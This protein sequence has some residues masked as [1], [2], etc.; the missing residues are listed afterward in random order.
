MVVSLFSF[1]KL[2]TRWNEKLVTHMVPSV[3]FLIFYW[4][5]K[6]KDSGAPVCSS[7]GEEEAEPLRGETLPQIPLPMSWGHIP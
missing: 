2:L 7:F 4:S 3:R 1:L 5:M 6:F